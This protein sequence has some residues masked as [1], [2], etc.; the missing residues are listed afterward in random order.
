MQAVQKYIRMSPRKLRLI[1]KAVVKLDPSEALVHLKFT[2]KNAADPLSKVIKSALANAKTNFG[3]KPENLRFKEIQVM[4]GPTYKRWRAVSRGMAH[5]IMK[6]T[7]HIKVVL[8]EK[9]GPKS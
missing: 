9:N 6:R 8:E 7:S 3:A 1:A 2:T 4:E 5:S